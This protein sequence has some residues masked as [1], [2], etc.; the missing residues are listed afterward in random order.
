MQIERFNETVKTTIEANF[1]FCNFWVKRQEEV[2]MSNDRYS[3][4]K[5]KVFWW[6]SPVDEVVD[7]FIE[8]EPYEVELLEFAYNKFKERASARATLVAGL[9]STKEEEERPMGQLP[10]SETETQSD[11][12]PKRKATHP[13]DA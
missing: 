9:P 6:L 5:H 7:R 1:R 3:S 11:P 13:I 10:S 4:K 2:E 12:Y 8:A